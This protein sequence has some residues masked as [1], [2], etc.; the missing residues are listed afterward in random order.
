M[1]DS[2]VKVVFLL[3]T[4]IGAGVAVFILDLLIGNLWHYVSLRAHKMRLRRHLAPL[5]NHE[6]RL[7]LRARNWTRRYFAW[8]LNHKDWFTPAEEK[9]IARVS[10]NMQPAIDACKQAGIA[11]KTILFFTKGLHPRELL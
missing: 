9:E 3:P 5:S 2:A 6:R 8:W 7:L 4:L 1:T 10:E 11:E